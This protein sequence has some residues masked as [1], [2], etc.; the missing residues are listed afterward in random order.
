MSRF[1]RI[2]ANAWRRTAGAI[3][4]PAAAALAAC[5]LASPASAHGFGQRYD[6]P[7]P[8]SLYLYGTAAVVI[9]TF[10]VVGLFVRRT[11]HARDYPQ[12]D[13]FAHPAGRMLAHPGLVLL[14]KLVALVLFVVTVAAGFI[15]DQNPY[16]NIA[17]T[18]VWIIVW[19]G[20]AY[21]SA[22]VGD[23]WAL[24]N[25]WRTIYEGAESLYRRIAGG[26]RISPRLHYP[27]ALGVW[28]AVV[29]LL[30]FAWFELIYP[31]P[32]VP[33]TIACFAVGYS[34]LTL[35]GM[36]LFGRE[37][38]LRH[39]EVFSVVFGTFARF[40][41]TEARAGPRREL[42]L[43][44]FGAGLLDSRP[45]SPSMT[46]FVLLLLS[47]V[48]YDGLLSTPEWASLENAVRALLRDPGEL[49]LVAIRSVGLVAFWLLFLGIYVA[50]SAMMSAAAGGNH[51]PIE[52]AQ[53]F[54]FTLIPIAVGY[55]LA[56]YLV[57]LLIQGQYIVPL[58]SDPFG[59]GWNLFGTAGYRVDIAVVGARFA[60]YAA[61]AAIVVG[62][63]AAVCLAHV[64]AMQVFAHRRAA[65]RSQV[66]LTALMV[67]YTFV[68]L[69]ILAEPIVARPEPAQ[70]S[71]SA[72]AEVA[73]PAEAALPEPGSGVLK[74]VG[75]DKT[76]RV[77]LTY[78]VLGS[79][80]HDGTKTTVADLLYAYMF[81]YRWGVRSEGSEARYDPF[82]DSA[83]ASMRTQL[84]GLRATGSDAVSRSFR[85]GDVDFV[86]ELFTIDVYATV[87]P[88]DPERDAVIAP[89]WSTLPWHLIVLMEE[90]VGRGWAAFSQAEAARR[91]VEWLDLVRSQQMSGRLASLVET[92]EREGYRP[93][94]LRP[95]VGVEEA[96]RRWAAL[97]AFH[98]AHGH[99][100]VTNGPYQLKRWSA[101]SVTLE[102]FRD[103]TYPLGV[104]SYD[105]YAT[106][107]RGYITKVER[108]KN[109]I[110]LFGDIETIVK[111]ARNYRIER[112]PMQSVSRD[113]LKRA[114]PEC[115]YVV[116][117]DNSRIVLAGTAA[118]TENSTFEVDLDGSLTAGRYT[119]LALIAVNGNVM[120]ADIRRIPVSISTNP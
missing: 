2:S 68:S 83:T 77:K 52:L 85:I 4:L 120:N 113:A 88:E 3:R 5:A 104:G 66:P 79:A 58:I 43:R 48:L 39:G 55:H 118:L 86:R 102:S 73:I 44:P 119:M 59:Y 65:L 100:L 91:G 92:F 28:P 53:S 112:E 105:A 26:R 89:P 96:R 84:A 35:T 40:A 29:L 111:F 60:W 50:V 117:D 47:T 46:A 61:V 93:A 62:H 70:P 74:A 108:E 95:L 21:V 115:R 41:P 16:R 87:V 82:I 36:A 7:L 45:A 33:A 64:K 24:I 54:V 17:P 71:V 25:P 34:I 81:A 9:V 98:K 69:S 12:F 67:V 75:P 13:L 32:A 57:F 56:H 37:T 15:G 8:L 18:M 30:A 114:A 97:A 101:E 103:L 19:V 63:I 22:F 31:A 76:A 106:P 80:F 49:E 20:L 14:L 116:M 78:R 109:R 10:A 38:W 1:I 107:R 90:A 27:E 6:L 72:D 110:R 42:I 99:F 11:S 23:L 51:S 94:A